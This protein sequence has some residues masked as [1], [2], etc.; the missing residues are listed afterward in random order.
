MAGQP[1]QR[2]VIP[3]GASPVAGLDP[4]EF[5]CAILASGGKIRDAAVVLRIDVSDLWRKLN[6]T[7]ESR[8]LYHDARVQ[9]AHLEADEIEEQITAL[10]TLADQVEL[11]LVDPQA[12]QASV[13]ARTSVINSKQWLMAKRAPKDYGEKQQLD[14]TGGINVNIK[15]NFGT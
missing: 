3:P 5:T 6:A 2:P 14:V 4:V 15:G 9:R 12:A 8:K 7:E 13:R 1:A 10:R 11:G